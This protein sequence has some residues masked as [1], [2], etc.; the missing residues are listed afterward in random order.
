M[1]SFQSQPEFCKF[2]A[3]LVSPFRNLYWLIEIF[4]S[5]TLVLK[6]AFTLKSLFSSQNT[7][8]QAALKTSLE[9][10]LFQNDDLLIPLYLF[11]DQP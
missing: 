1:V 6:A 7:I 11:A 3:F 8:Y 10:G 2:L 5:N 4:F 9:F